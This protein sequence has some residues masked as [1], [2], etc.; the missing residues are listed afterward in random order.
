MCLWHRWLWFV[1][2][3]G[4][5]TD[6]MCIC[7]LMSKTL[8]EQQQSSHSSRRMTNCVI[9][10][11]KK[12]RGKERGG[13]ELRERREAEWRQHFQPWGEAA[14]REAIVQQHRPY[15]RASRRSQTPSLYFFLCS[16]L[17]VLWEKFKP[18]ARRL[19]DFFTLI[20]VV[21]VSSG[22][23]LVLYLPEIDEQPDRNNI[24]K[25]TNRMKLTTEDRLLKG[26][27]HTDVDL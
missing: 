15:Q 14:H 21:F 7:A 9:G 26:S 5:N 12:N 8:E 19:T 13:E 3:R 17:A 23:V 6:F 1:H 2:V 24:T 11:Q 25:E 22:F 4:L 27:V 10:K 18:F 20:G 16:E